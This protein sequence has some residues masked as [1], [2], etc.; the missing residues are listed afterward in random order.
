MNFDSLP[1]DKPAG[2]VVPEGPYKAKIVDPQ[3]RQ[4]KD[5]SK[6]MYLNFKLDLFDYRTR[7]K[8]G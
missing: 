1:N 4:P 5:T 8:V 3:M 7:E 2:F 6:P